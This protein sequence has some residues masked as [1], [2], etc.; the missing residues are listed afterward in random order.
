MN[1]FIEMLWNGTAIWQQVVEGVAVAYLYPDGR[2]VEL[3]EP[4]EMS[5]VSGE[6]VAEIGGA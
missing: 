3:V 6:L 1:G 4:Y 2:I 5:V